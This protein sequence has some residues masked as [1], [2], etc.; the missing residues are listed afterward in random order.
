MIIADDSAF[1]RKVLSDLFTKHKDF[2]VAGT[3]RNGQEAVDLVAKLKPDLL[4][5]DVH[6]PVLDGL[7]ALKIIM[8]E[9]PVTSLNMTA[10]ELRSRNLTETAI[11][12]VRN[13]LHCSKKVTSLLQILRFHFSESLLRF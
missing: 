6:M 10:K 13:A 7:S 12:E 1:M 3:A 11:L 2:Q 8:K 5:L 9:N 4:T